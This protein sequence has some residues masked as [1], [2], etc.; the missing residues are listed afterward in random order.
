VNVLTVGI[1]IVF[2]QNSGVSGS[3][4]AYNLAYQFFQ[5][6]YG[7]LAVSVI[8]AF[9][10]ELTRLALAGD[11][12]GF[13]ERFM[14]ALR[15]TLLLVVPVTA[16]YLVLARPIMAVFFNYRSLDQADTL[17]IGN[18]LL[19]FS[20]GLPAFALYLLSMR[21][22]YAY[23]D[24]KTPFLINLG[25]CAL[26]LVLAVLLRP[27]GSP[28]LALAFALGYVPFAVVA[29]VLLHRK[30]G[31]LPWATSVPSL[32]RIT[33]AGIATAA[34]VAGVALLVGSDEGA[35]ALIRVVAG[36][37]VGAAVY[38]GACV[39][40]RVPEL[41]QGLAIVRHPG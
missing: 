4:Q 15:L 31:G 20:I 37:A 39:L 25:E 14:L 40:L 32:V 26:T 17:L 8:T 41:R 29:I 33:G 9:L 6:P 22:F 24:T 35:G 5:L 34:V 36:V 27:Q 28:G 1:I 2:A 30:A 16:G 18:T 7:L 23:K 12:R 13:G 38:L 21:G 11:R 10:P 19:T 3:T